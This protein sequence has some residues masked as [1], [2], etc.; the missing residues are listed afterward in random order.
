[1]AID[2]KRKVEPSLVMQLQASRYTE[3]NEAHT[4]GRETLFVLGAES[5]AFAKDF[6]KNVGFSNEISGKSL[7]NA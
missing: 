7:F 6:H 4:V 3:A 5:Y 2:S 1:M